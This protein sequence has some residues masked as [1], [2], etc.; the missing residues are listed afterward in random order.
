MSKPPAKPAATAPTVEDATAIAQAGGTAVN[1]D[2]QTAAEA[3]AASQAAMR[4]EADARNVTL[5]D[6]Q[7]QAIAAA[8][9]SQLEARG[10]FEPPPAAPAAGI[11]PPDTAQPPEPTTTA[12]E[13]PRRK[14]F[15]ERFV[16]R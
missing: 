8:T 9:I 13:P 1:P 11:A 3:Q 5:T 6:E 15:A 7:I 14:T 12:P 4:T 2:T 16:G 10:A